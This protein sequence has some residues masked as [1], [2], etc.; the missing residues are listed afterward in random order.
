MLE[1]NWVSAGLKFTTG[2]YTNYR[3]PDDYAEV[4]Q[5]LHSLIFPDDCTLFKRKTRALLTSGK[6]DWFSLL[7][8]ELRLMILCYLPSQSVEV[9]RQVSGG[10]AFIPL[11]G[12]FWLS[13][14]SSPE[15]AHLSEYIAQ[16]FGQQKSGDTPQWFL[17]MQDAKLQNKNRL[18][19]I[20]HNEMLIDKMLQRRGY[21]NAS[22]KAETSIR[23][24]YTQL[25]VCPDEPHPA[26]QKS[27]TTLTWRSEVRFDSDRPFTK[28]K[29]IT[30]TYGCSY[31][32]K[33]LTGLVFHTDEEEFVLGFRSSKPGSQIDVRIEAHQSNNII[34]QSDSRGIFD[35]SIAKQ[36]VQVLQLRKYGKIVLN[37]ASLCK[38][39]GVRAELALV[40]T[41]HR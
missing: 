32:G 37:L 1:G 15:Y 26:Y 14:L 5:A 31:G 22:S 38:I 29:A 12:T 11:E 4:E 33:Y 6:P 34:M 30:P 25:V 28:V 13:R 24:Q 23:T 10:M 35:V 3:D 27:E 40:C 19:I 41:Q 18:R 39:S 21:L 8:A 36:N 16:Q 17:A 2:D 20:Q 9:I 7:P